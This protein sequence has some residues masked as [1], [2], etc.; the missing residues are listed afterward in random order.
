MI[1]D[2]PLATSSLRRWNQERKANHRE[3]KNRGTDDGGG[4]A[5]RR[6]DWPDDSNPNRQK[7]QRTKPVVGTD[8]RQNLWRNFSLHRGRPEGPKDCQ[9]NS[10]DEPPQP[11]TST[12]ARKA[13]ARSGQSQ[14]TITI[15]ATNNGLLGFQRSITKPEHGAAPWSARMKPTPVLPEDCLAITARARTS[16]QR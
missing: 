14:P 13:K 11:I 8:T 9:P 1:Q 16:E 10:G 7:D 3:E 2:L 5:A 15:V 12:G 4:D 6:R